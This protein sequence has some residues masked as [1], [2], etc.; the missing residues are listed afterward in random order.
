M[1]KIRTQVLAVPDVGLGLRVARF[2]RAEDPCFRSLGDLGWS[3]ETLF[4]VAAGYAHDQ[5]PGD[6]RS[7]FLSSFIPEAEIPAKINDR[8]ISHR[9]DQLRSLGQGKIAQ[10]PLHKDLV[11][12]FLAPPQ[13]HA[14]TRTR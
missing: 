5:L 12:T 9:I 10:W 7:E 4:S 1:P 6:F 2:A 3:I 14:R 11:S 8:L 13:D